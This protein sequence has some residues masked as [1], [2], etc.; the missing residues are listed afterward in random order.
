M[1]WGPGAPAHA[2]S[3]CNQERISE[4]N[5]GEI[6]L[7][8]MDGDEMTRVIWKKI[9]ER[10]ILPR[11]D[12]DLT[13]FDLGMAHR[14][15]TDDRVTTAAA[16]ATSEYGVAL[17]CTTR[18]ADEGRMKEFGLK[19]MW[20]T[21]DGT[22][23]SILNGTLFREPIICSNVPRTV[24]HWNLPVVI[25]RHA[26]GDLYRSAEADTN[27]RQRSCGDSGRRSDLGGATRPLQRPRALR[28]PW[29]R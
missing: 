3:V 29:Q 6:P 13:Y 23:R 11:L 10:L 28:R 9:R 19:Q 1:P 15:A 4:Q 16:H 21:P 7:V 26:F 25:G 24:P 5:Q 8:E 2:M 12:I 17:K 27:E 14:D 20:K 18:T 22:I